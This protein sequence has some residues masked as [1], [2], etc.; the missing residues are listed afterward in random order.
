VARQPEP[1]ALRPSLQ[2]C[3]AVQF[4]ETG[5][6]AAESYLSR[7][8]TKATELLSGQVVRQAAALCIRVERSGEQKVLLLSSRGSG[9]WVVPKGTVERYETPRECAGR[10]AFE[11]AGITGKVSKRPV[12]FYTYIKDG[13]TSPLLVSV[14]TLQVKAQRSDFR[15]KGQR[16]RS[17]VSLQEAAALVAEPELKGLLLGVRD[18]TK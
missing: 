1:A 17:W 2:S 9:R 12:G 15:E 11:E 16:V 10:E 5:A 6:M 8:A 4:N 14:F 7:L 18:A 13:K 3:K